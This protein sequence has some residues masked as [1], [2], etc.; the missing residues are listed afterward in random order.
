MLSIGEFKMDKRD[1]TG[2]MIYSNENIYEG[3][4]HRIQSL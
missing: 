2:K 3:K 1:G 4:F